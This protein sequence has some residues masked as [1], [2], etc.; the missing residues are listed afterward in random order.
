VA[1]TNV[2]FNERGLEFEAQSASID[3]ALH[4]PFFE[5]RHDSTSIP[6][7][8]GQGLGVHLHGVPCDVFKLD[9]PELSGPISN[10]CW[11]M[12]LVGSALRHRSTSSQ[13]RKGR[14]NQLAFASQFGCPHANG[15]SIRGHACACRLPGA[16]HM[17]P[18]AIGFAKNIPSSQTLNLNFSGLPMVR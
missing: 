11:K 15:G 9:D 2:D 8:L 16:A 5:P 3:E 12:P 17:G 4:T 7:P 18:F 10:L 6:D 13:A 14:S 1:I